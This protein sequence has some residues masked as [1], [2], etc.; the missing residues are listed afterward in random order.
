MQELLPLTEQLSLPAQS[1]F[2]NKQNT[3]LFQVDIFFSFYIIKTSK[4]VKF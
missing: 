1:F 2:V 3:D 4:C